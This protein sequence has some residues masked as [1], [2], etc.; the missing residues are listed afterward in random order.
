MLVIAGVA[1][2]ILVDK[3]GR[4]RTMLWFLPGSALA[5]GVLAVAF[6]GDVEGT[7]GKWAVI[8]GLFAYILF[9]GIGIQ[10]V[11]WLIGPEVLP[12]RVRGPAT[13][14]AT[15]SVWGFDLLIAGTALTMINL[16]GRSGTFLLYAVM[17][18]LCIAFVLRRVPET[19]G[20]SL[21][22][23]EDSLRRPGSF[24]D[25]LAVRTPGR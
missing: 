2:A 17:N 18:L 7:V 8:G 25:N 1:G 11:V 10:A 13:S 6:L 5:M 3:A 14:L 15:M 22:E 23:I 12:L 4:R 21:E 24:R 19:R 20:R 9:N 16:V